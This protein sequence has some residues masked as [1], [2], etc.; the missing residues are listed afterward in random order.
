MSKD[1]SNNTANTSTTSSSTTTTTTQ[2][3]GINSN[4]VKPSS[5]QMIKENFNSQNEKK[6]SG[7]KK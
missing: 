7:S 6:D 1:S 5:P 3:P 4:D 2:L